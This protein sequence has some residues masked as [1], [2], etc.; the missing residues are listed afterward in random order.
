MFSNVRVTPF[1]KDSLRG[2]AS[3]KVGDAVYLTGLKVVMG[4]NGL[5][6]GM[7]SQQNKAGEYKDIYFPSSKEARGTL[8]KMVLDEYHKQIG[9]ATE[10]P[11][12]PPPTDTTP[13]IPVN[14]D[15]IPF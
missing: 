15:D 5:F 2:L 12:T 6:V 8:Q 9:A 3:V 7:P 11:A 1:E 13:P 4:K 14:D 10:T